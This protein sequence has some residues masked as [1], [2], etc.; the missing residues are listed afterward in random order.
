[1]EEAI[2]KVKRLKKQY[3][4]NLQTKTVLTNINLEVKQGEVLSLIGLNGAGKSTLLKIL[5]GFNNPTSGTV[6]INGMPVNN[7]RVRANIG[8]MPENPQ[9]Y[10]DLSALDFLSY[11]GRLFNQDKKTALKL[12]HQLLKSVG[13]KD[14]QNQPIRTF[15]KGMRQR[16]G[17]AQ[18]IIGNPKV[19]FLDEPLDGLDPM[20]RHYLKNELLKLKKV[21][22]TI[23]ICSH[24]LSD[25]A[26]LS[27]RIGVIHQGR[28]TTVQTTKQF[29]KSKE[30][31]EAFV[32]YIQQL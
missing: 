2:L 23:I 14:S 5:V 29:T 28:L 16:L 22:V 27:D 8:F 10:P 15:S 13:L 24:I 19:L 21:G 31:E 6:S 1:M 7:P 3:H 4:L 12:S 9:F 32:K 25:L 20:G 18:A 11:V 26:S 30:L 17:F